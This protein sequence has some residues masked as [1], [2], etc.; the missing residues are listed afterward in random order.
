MQ[1]YFANLLVWKAPLCFWLDKGLIMYSYWKCKAISVSLNITI[2]KSQTNY[3]IFLLPW[4]YFWW[5]DTHIF[6]GRLKERRRRFA[7]NLCCAASSILKWKKLNQWWKW[8]QRYQITILHIILMFCVNMSHSAY[9][10]YISI[11]L[12]KY[13]TYCH[14][15]YGNTVEEG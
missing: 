14:L 12:E 10:S 13:A 5:M 9:T 15:F 11:P 6:Q 8:K 1:F 3:T 2:S 7:N 4:T